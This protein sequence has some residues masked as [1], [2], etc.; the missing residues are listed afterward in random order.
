MRFS[1]FLALQYVHQIEPDSLHLVPSAQETLEMAT[2]GSAKALGLHHEVGSLEPGKKADAII[3]DLKK[4]H[5]VPMLDVVTNLVHY[6]NGNDVETTIID[7]ELVMH[8]REIRTVDESKVLMDGQRA[9]EE[10]WGAFNARNRQFP[11]VA[12]KFKFFT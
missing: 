5:L 1:N 7:G 9:S 11:D 6:A 12:D 3:V 8:Q 2:V 4:P 10:V